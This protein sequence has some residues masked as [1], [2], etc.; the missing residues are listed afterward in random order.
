MVILLVARVTTSTGSAGRL[1]ILV[2]AP[3][4]SGQGLSLQRC[5]SAVQFRSAPPH[6]KERF[7]G[8]EALTFVLWKGRCRSEAECRADRKLP[9]FSLTKVPTQ[10]T[11]VAIESP[12]NS[13]HWQLNSVRHRAFW[14]P[15]CIFLAPLKDA[16][17]QED[18]RPH[19]SSCLSEVV[20]PPISLC[21]KGAH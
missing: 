19:L 20:G 15:P 12:I 16:V 8:P 3:Y 4:L 14:K 21:S 11:S 2:P 1:L 13:F 18:H 7:E 5:D 10:R 17:G 6:Q 9:T